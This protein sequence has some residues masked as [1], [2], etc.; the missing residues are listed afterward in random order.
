MRPNLC[1]ICGSNLETQED[2]LHCIYCGADYPTHDMEEITEALSSVLSDAKMEMLAHARRNLYEMTHKENPSKDAIMDACARVTAL[3]PE[4]PLAGLYSA[5]LDNDPAVLNHYLDG[6][7]VDEATANE[8][9][10]W[11]LQGLDPKN[12]TSIQHFIS[13]HFK[14]KEK[15]DYLTALEKELAKLDE[16]MYDTTLPRDVF[17]A[18]SSADMDEVVRLSNVLESNGFSVFIAA[19]NLRHGLGAAKK[20]NYQLALYEAIDHCKV[21][22]FL[23]T[24][25]SRSLS[26]DALSIELPYIAKNRPEMRRV[27]YVLDEPSAISI[28]V[29]A[30]LSSVFEG[31]EWCRDDEDLIKRVGDFTTD[32][33]IK[34]PRCGANN[35]SDSKHC[36]HCGA[37]LTG[38]ED[39]SNLQDL[40]QKLIEE[41]KEDSRPK[42]PSKAGKG[43]IVFLIIYLVLFAAI[44]AYTIPM[45]FNNHLSAILIGLLAGVPLTLLG[46][47]TGL[48]FIIKGRARK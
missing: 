32:L 22:L 9:M 12:A 29:K 33:P 39:T 36:S 35:P 37:S 18:Y 38:E 26:C 7:S 40:V 27:Q 16:G 30:K 47:I 2:H 19:R 28:A 48:V 1:Q 4:D 5:S 43:K 23:S 6:A 24:A 42:G 41:K 10:K 17:L 8:Y 34:C 46:F 25:N 3:F 31:L 21:L 11:L 44:A 20:D 45:S 15:L 13:R 14:D